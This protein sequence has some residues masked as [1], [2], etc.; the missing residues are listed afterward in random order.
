MWAA[1]RQRIPSSSS[2]FVADPLRLRGV[3]NLAGTIDVTANIAHMEQKCRGPVVTDMLGG[4]PTA[5]PER[6]K[7]ASANMM[8][9][10]ACPRS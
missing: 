8:L 1:T 4:T 3:I 6:Y 2:L 9:R 10:W 5:V 7:E